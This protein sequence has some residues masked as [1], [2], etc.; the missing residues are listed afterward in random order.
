MSK[1]IGLSKKVKSLFGVTEAQA[2]KELNRGRGGSFLEDT[3]TFELDGSN[4]RSS[5][6]EISE[7]FR[8]LVGVT[9]DQADKELNQ[10]RRRS[11]FEDLE[12]QINKKLKRVSRRSFLEDTKAHELDGYY[13][14]LSGGKIKL[15]ENNRTFTKRKNRGITT[16]KP[17]HP[18]DFSKRSQKRMRNLFH[19]I[20]PSKVSWPAKIVLTYPGKFPEKMKSVDILHRHLKALIRTLIRDCPGLVI[21]KIEF[22]ERGVPHF[23][24]LFY[25]QIKSIEKTKHL[26]MQEFREFLSKRWNTILFKDR[27]LFELTD[28]EFESAKI[29]S[30][31]AGVHVSLAISIPRVKGYICKREDP[32]K[33]PSWFKGRRFWGVKNK[34]DYMDCFIDG[35]LTTKELCEFKDFILGELKEDFKKKNWKLPPYI[36]RFER[37]VLLHLYLNKKKTRKI[38][39]DWFTEKGYDISSIE[40]KFKKYWGS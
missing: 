38:A 37:G 15:K 24:I 17:D 34:S 27:A 1:S 20:N 21:W 36:Y 29:D 2:N 33:I 8:S 26:S 13:F 35:M 10:G 14:K 6:R 39:I 9:N 40:N 25:R 28:K 5:N 30:R 32:D 16:R 18:I 19:D 22:Q 31:M 12:T 11:L 3:V 7:K 23:E 4:F